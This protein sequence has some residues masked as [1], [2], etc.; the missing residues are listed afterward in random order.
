MHRLSLVGVSEG[1]FSLRCKVFPLLWILLLH[2][3]GSRVRVQELWH[4]GLV[5]PQHVE[6]SQNKDQTSVPCIARWILKPWATREM[7]DWLLF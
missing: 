2:S 7:R 3:V 4:T 5:A 1:Y 6:F